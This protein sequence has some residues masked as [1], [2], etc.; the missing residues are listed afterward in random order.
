MSQGNYRTNIIWTE[1]THLT[2]KLGNKYIK[3]YNNKFNKRSYSSNFTKLDS[4][5]KVVRDGKSYILD[6]WIRSA[7]FSS[8]YQKKGKQK[9]FET[10]QYA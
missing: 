1:V 6:K 5:I 8:Y 10:I 7:F 3:E 2:P 9:V 4:G